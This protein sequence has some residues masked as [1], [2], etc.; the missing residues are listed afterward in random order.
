MIAR[1]VDGNR[2][3]I[4]GVTLVARNV[5]GRPGVATDAHGVAR[6]ELDWPAPVTSGD[7]GWIVVEAHAPGWTRVTRQQR[8]HGTGKITTTFGDVV[9]GPAGSIAGLVRDRAGRPLEGA[10]VSLVQAASTSTPAV[11][12]RRR[13]LGEGFT[14]LAK[15]WS[16]SAKTDARGHYRFDGVPVG[17]VSATAIWPGLSIGYSRPVEV[18]SGSIAEAPP[19]VLRSVPPENRIR[20]VVRDASGQPIAD[21]QVSA[22]SK[23]GRR[24]AAPQTTSWTD[25]KG[26]FLAVVLSG[27]KYTLELERTDPSR[28]LTVHDVAAGTRGLVAAFPAER[29]LEVTAV[30]PAGESVGVT[31]TAFEESNVRLPL[32]SR[33]LPDSGT[34]FFVP[35]QPFGLVVHARGYRS[36]TVGPFDPDDLSLPIEV[37]LERSASVRGSVVAD[38]RAVGGATVHLHPAP[39]SPAF[40]TFRCRAGGRVVHRSADR[41]A[42]EYRHRRGRGVRAVRPGRRSLRGARRA[43]RLGTR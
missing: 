38:G 16:Q 23:R 22:F 6:L 35:A 42:R 7:S 3:P 26:E 29:V 13:V 17:S 4:E 2:R 41:D 12:E 31:L 19:L 37:A 18:A 5:A 9:L 33:Q 36:K 32:G 20:G 30:G 24:D 8:V 28:Y 43:R 27:Q 10:F 1:C 21:V 34:E 14:A 15:G 39:S 11:E 25:A 40:H